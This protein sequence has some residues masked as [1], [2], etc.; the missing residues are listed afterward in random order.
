MSRSRLALTGLMLPVLFVLSACGGGSA[1]PPPEPLP[2]LSVST[3][4]IKEDLAVGDEL[5]LKIEGSW[6]YAG[7]GQV[8]LQLRDPGGSFSLPAIQ[9]A[10]ADQRLVL[11]FSSLTTLPAGQRTGSLE[12]RAC[13]DAACAQPFGSAAAT[14]AYELSVSAV[15]DWETHQRNARHNGEVPI[16][17]NPAK[18][19]KV[20]E[21][22]RPAGSEP[23]GGINPVV[24]RAGKVFVTTDVYFGEAR[25]TA[26][27]EA[28]GSQVWAQS[29]GNVP[30]F[31]PPAVGAGKVFA[32]VTG[33]EQTF[34]WAFDLE[35][36]S[37]AHK[38]AFDGQ[39]PHFL[40]PTVVDDV[41]FQ[42]SGY[43]G[44]DVIAF[45]TVDGSRK[46]RATTGGAWDMFTP[47]VDDKSTYH[48]NGQS[49]VILDKLSGKETARISDPFGG[50]SGYAYHGAPVLGSRGNVI[51]FAGGAFSG[52]ASANVEQYDQRKLSSFLIAD[53]K[54]EWSTAEAYLTA[55]A[56]GR[57]VL[58]AARNSPMSLDAIDEAT[59]K[60]QWSWTA[61]GGN[62]T[63]FHRNLVLTRTH[64]FVSTNS[65]VYAIDLSTKKAVWTYPA[66]GM[67]AISAERTLYIATGARESDGRLIAVRLK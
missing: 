30:A 57:G 64:L 32:A 50:N 18:F 53:K 35:T 65:N 21:W 55:P 41:A 67:L 1:P 52:R 39:W 45:S 4:A 25:L 19:S 42:G 33:H 49:L 59:G 63:S 47:A 36:G 48:H 61:P 22:Q 16:R 26:L 8:Y 3:A 23:I 24:T 5:A 14:L 13:K 60:I 40:A 34:L 10:S 51:A 58:Y 28:D 56:V 46:W 27:K 31:N 11:S 9:A 37:F 44:G 38:A 7:T 62:D 15:A 20:W 6:S 12:I 2:Q 66:P 17:L 43:Y 29:M 54:H